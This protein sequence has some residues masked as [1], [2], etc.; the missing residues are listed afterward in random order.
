ML[1]ECAV[2][3]VEL[4]TR[5]GRVSERYETYAEARRRVEQFPAD[6]LVGLAFIFQELPDG[7]E[8]LVR[9]DG[10]PLQFHRR[11]VEEAKD[12]SDEPLPLVEGAPG[13]LESGGKLRFLEPQPTS[14]DWNDPPFLG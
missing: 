10:K 9:E 4:T 14:D 3:I 13:L 7:S 6:S 1:S 8:R 11:L 2:F 12:C 5:Q